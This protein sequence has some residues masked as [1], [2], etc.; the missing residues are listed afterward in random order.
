MNINSS[1]GC[2]VSACKYNCDGKN[3]TL[4]DIRVGNNCNCEDGAC[5]CCENYCKK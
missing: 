5:T 3:C 1:I 2:E 4:D